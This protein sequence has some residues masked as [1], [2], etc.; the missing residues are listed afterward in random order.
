MI[1]ISAA[2]INP[3]RNMG[4]SKTKYPLT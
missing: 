2:T 4:R 3:E 1:S